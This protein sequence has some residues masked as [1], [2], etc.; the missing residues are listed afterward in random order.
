MLQDILFF[1]L[2]LVSLF[3]APLFGQYMALIFMGKIPGNILY[4]ENKL[5]RLLGVDG[6]LEMDWKQYLKALLWFNLFGFL[7]VL[8]VLL[9][10]GILP[11]NPRNLPHVPFWTAFNTAASFVTNTNW[12]SYAGETTLSYLSQMIGLTSQNFLSAA[13]GLVALVAFARGVSGK[14]ASL[15]NFFVD[16][17]RS[18]LYILLPLAFLF[19]L[20][21]S[22]EGVI[23]NFSPYIEATTLEGAKQTIPMGPVASQEAIKMLGTNGG[24]FFNVNSAHPFENPTFL[25][26]LL[27]TI[28][29]FFLPIACIFL[30]GSLIRRPKEAQIFFFVMGF[31]YLMELAHCLPL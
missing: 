28:A 16:M 29:I 31:L 25:T 18:I 11:L 2:L 7:F 1:S 19:A 21:L 30:F 17:T 8:A 10:Q 5:L 3:F 20:I 13:T 6:T 24:G 27:E 14:S 9:L 22:F 15:G 4:Y 26:N 23:Q 12:Q